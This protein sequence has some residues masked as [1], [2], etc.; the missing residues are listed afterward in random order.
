MHSLDQS[1]SRNLTKFK[2]FL[3]H[4]EFARF[5]KNMIEKDDHL[6]KL[7]KVPSQKHAN[8]HFM[9][10]IQL[11]LYSL[12]EPWRDGVFSSYLVRFYQFGFHK[13]TINHLLI[14]LWRGHISWISG[15]TFLCR[16]CLLSSPGTLLCLSPAN[17]WNS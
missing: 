13:K 9:S 7:Q 12:S 2:S 16:T 10:N 17:I 3:K 14:D 8:T 5:R 4:Q 1:G 11:P 6:H 15:L